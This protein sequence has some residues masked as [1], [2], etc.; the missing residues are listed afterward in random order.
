MGRQSHERAVVER[1]FGV[2]GVG[3]LGETEEEVILRIRAEPGGDLQ[4]VGDALEDLEWRSRGH[5]AFD[6][7]AQR[8]G[9]PAHLGPSIQV[10]RP[11]SSARATGSRLVGHAMGASTAKS[12]TSGVVDGD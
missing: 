12:I 2:T 9:Q 4:L 5:E 1:A 8:V 7:A 6:H 11:R 10:S 3:R